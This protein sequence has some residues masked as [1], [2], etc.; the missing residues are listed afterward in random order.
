M[1]DEIVV[2]FIVNFVSAA[3]GTNVANTNVWKGCCFGFSVEP[4]PIEWDKSSLI[5]MS[6]YP[7]VLCLRSNRDRKVKGKYIRYIVFW[8]Y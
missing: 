4:G 3:F 5:V 8:I 2:L 6:F 7:R 1:Y